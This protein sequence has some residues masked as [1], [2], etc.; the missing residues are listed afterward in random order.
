MQSNDQHTLMVAGHGIDPTP[1]P[2]PDETGPFP[3][4]RQQEPRHD[5]SVWRDMAAWVVLP[6]VA[7]LLIRIFVIGCYA[8]PS[9]SMLG[10]I[11]PGDKVATL[12]IA[13]WFSRLYRGD[14]VVFRDPANWLADKG[15]D[16]FGGSYLIKRLIGL[17]GD[18]VECSG[19][20]QPIKVNGVAIDEHAYL[21]DGV[22]PSA[23][24]F[25]VEVSS[26]HVFVMGDNRSNS[27]DSRYHQDDGDHGLVPV[28]DVVGVAIV[29]YWPIGRIGTLPGHADVFAQVPDGT[30]A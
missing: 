10:T 20:G 25:R 24:A 30:V 14:I 15:R 17:P 28:D 4:H 8:I 5:G 13:P 7:V 3:A 1:M 29:R 9:E 21:R 22:A 16:G 2:D 23:F 18:V 19:A 12:K 11:A 27:A 6:V 26:G